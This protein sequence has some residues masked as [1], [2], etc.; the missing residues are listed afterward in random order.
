[1][2]IQRRV[3]FHHNTY[4][5]QRAE[6]GYFLRPRT[7]HIYE[8][9]NFISPGIVPG[10]VRN[11]YHSHTGKAMR[12]SLSYSIGSATAYERI[13]LPGPLYFGPGLNYIPHRPYAYRLSWMGQVYVHRLHSRVFPDFFNQ[14]SLVNLQYAITKGNALTKNYLIYR[15]CANLK[16][17]GSPPLPYGFLWPG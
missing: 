1:M 3:R 10:Y 16:A 7:T 6:M 11:L 17:H 14:G 4:I 15:K 13:T 12:C 5:L 9:T 8:N 2:Y